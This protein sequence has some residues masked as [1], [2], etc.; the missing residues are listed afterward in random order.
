[1]ILSFEL[2]FS[3]YGK[4]RLY[5]LV[6]NLGRTQKAEAQ[7]KELIKNQPY[8]YHWPD[9]SSAIIRVR[10]V[11]AKEARRV[12]KASLGFLGYGWMVDSILSEGKINA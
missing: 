11:D 9:G 5:A 7:G 6:K 10:E 3:S 1:M 12:R 2:S 4:G 8:P